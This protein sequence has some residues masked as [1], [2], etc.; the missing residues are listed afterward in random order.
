[1]SDR[2]SSFCFVQ[3]GENPAVAAFEKNNMSDFFDILPSPVSL[4]FQLC[5]IN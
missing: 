2:S 3:G 4:C 5:I 1:M